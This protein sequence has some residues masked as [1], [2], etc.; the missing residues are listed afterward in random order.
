MDYLLYLM[1]RCDFDVTEILKNLE[2]LNKAF[3]SF[4]LRGEEQAMEQSRSR[5]CRAG[6]HE[7]R[8]GIRDVACV[9]P[10]RFDY[11]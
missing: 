10:G 5:M 6:N 4:E 11:S 1:F 2:E 8:R 3:L 7:I 9:R